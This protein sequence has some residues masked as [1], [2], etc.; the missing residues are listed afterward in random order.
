MP[1][2]T[3]EHS[4]ARRQ[5]ILDAARIAFIRDGFHATSMQDIQREAGLSA[6]AI[7]L[8]FK[9]K[10]E[11]VIAIAADAIATVSAAFDIPSLDEA[12]PGLDALI[13]QFLGVAARLQSEKHIFPVVVQV[14]SEALR[15]PPLH[16]ELV[17]LFSQVMIRLT[18]LLAECQASGRIGPGVDP[19][20]LA[21]ALVGLVQGYIIQSTLLAER[22]SFER[23]RAG[24]HALMRSGAVPPS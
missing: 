19:A 20:S 23:Y 3:A 7:Y 9:S 1:R 14:W 13:D 16:R 24:V 6:G 11:I 18:R 8:Y 5:Q 17:A 2:V 10:D 12:L 15:N 21:M 4:N 22:T